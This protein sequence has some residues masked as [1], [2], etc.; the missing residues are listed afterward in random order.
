MAASGSVGID[1]LDDLL[2]DPLRLLRP[3]GGREQQR[4]KDGQS[5]AHRS[6]YALNALRSNWN[7]TARYSAAL[8]ALAVK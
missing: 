2:I 1:P 3:T 5:E 7:R 8:R 4:G 6:P